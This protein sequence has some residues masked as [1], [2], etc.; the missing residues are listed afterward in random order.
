MRDDAAERVAVGGRRAAHYGAVI[1]GAR[2]PRERRARRTE[3]AR[4]ARLHSAE[5]AARSAPHRRAPGG[6]RRRRVGL[7]NFKSEDTL[8]R[9]KLVE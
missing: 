8:S 6:R 2:R 1:R 4:V 3:V 5:R 9:V 7:R